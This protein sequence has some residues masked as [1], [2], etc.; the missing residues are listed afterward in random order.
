MK[1]EEIEIETLYKCSC[2]LKEESLERFVDFMNL[3]QITSPDLRQKNA[4]KLSRIMVEKLKK[5]N[6]WPKTSNTPEGML[7]VNTIDILSVAQM[8]NTEKDAYQECLRFINNLRDKRKISQNSADRVVKQSRMFWDILPDIKDIF[9]LNTDD[10]ARTYPIYELVLEAAKNF[11][12]D[13]EHLITLALSLQLFESVK[14]LK[15]IKEEVSIQKKVNEIAKNYQIRFLEI[16]SE[17]GCLLFDPLDYQYNGTIRAVSRDR[18]RIIIRNIRR[19]YFSAH[20]SIQVKSEADHV[21]WYIECEIS[22]EEELSNF[23]EVFGNGSKENRRN[24]LRYV[25][26][27]EIYNIFL[28]DMLVRNR[29][30]EK[31]IRVLNLCS[32]ADKYIVLDKNTELANIQGFLKI[33]KTGNYNNRALFLCEDGIDVLTVDF[34]C[35]FYLEVV[36]GRWGLCTNFINKSDFYQRQLSSSFIMDM[37]KKESVEDFSK[38]L[39][40]YYVFLKKYVPYTERNAMT[41]MDTQMCLMM[42]YGCS[43]PNEINEEKWKQKIL[44]QCFSNEADD[45]CS[46]ELSY[47]KQTQCM[48]TK[49]G[50]SLENYAFY[51]EDDFDKKIDDVTIKLMRQK[52]YFVNYKKQKIIPDYITFD[53]MKR[54]NGIEELV[55]EEV[56]IYNKRYDYKI[57]NINRLQTIMEKNVLKQKMYNMFGCEKGEKE[58]EKCIR[59]FKILWH[60]QIYNIHNDRLKDFW[61]L[62][63]EKH[64]LGCVEEDEKIK[65]YFASLRKIANEKG[66]LIVAK[67]TSGDD[68]TLWNLYNSF[69]RKDGE[70]DLIVKAFSSDSING[71]LKEDGKEGYSWRGNH[72]RKVVFMVDNTLSGSSLNKML[73]FHI[74]GIAKSTK[75]KY[76]AF[77]PALKEILEKDENILV[78]VHIIFALLYDGIKERIEEKFGNIKMVIYN[79]IPEKY[80]INLETAGL[81]K[82]LYKLDIDTNRGGS[83]I[84]RYCN[85]P[86][87]YAFPK[88]VVESLYLVGLFQRRDEI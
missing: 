32:N 86:A 54:I 39:S 15:E 71:D 64:Y 82:K 65:K 25:A 55:R 68:T 47:D 46:E 50:I 31:F 10:G 73:E 57:E 26:E 6:Q 69:G 88:Q 16:I 81:I 5:L 20:E 38:T 13:N 60:F 63:F 11:K 79:R 56:I 61:N 58:K 85:M 28:P 8:E 78:E 80:K 9:S 51:S 59:L 14:N 83:F 1:N 34:Y 62:V 12:H 24:L 45:W 19:E 75:Y 77:E 70:R 2:E 66:A 52:Y 44:Q 27:Q 4:F 76:V 36:K 17:G 72:L 84:F 21:A 33:L 87:K 35:S 40:D 7:L 22:E 53:V 74:N 37:F 3:I 42:P 67:E 43:L 30:S 29:E 18:K 23:Q 41:K 48:L 49:K